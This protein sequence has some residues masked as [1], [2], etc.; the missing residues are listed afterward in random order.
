MGGGASLS[1]SQGLIDK[2]LSNIFPEHP[3][4]EMWDSAAF[5]RYV[6][7]LGLS[8]GHQLTPSRALLFDDLLIRHLN[9]S[10]LVKIADYTFTGSIMEGCIEVVKQS[11]AS[12]RY[13]APRNQG[14][15]NNS[16]LSRLL[17]FY[18]EDVARFFAPKQTLWVDRSTVLTHLHEALRTYQA[19][20]PSWDG[21]NALAFDHLTLDNARRLLTNFDTCNHALLE[22]NPPVLAPEPDGFIGFVWTR[23]DKEL[24]IKIGPKMLEVQ[25]WSP[26]SSY[27]AEGYWEIPITA[28]SEHLA[29][30]AG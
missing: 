5:R 13:S 8:E 23:N 16:L 15:V 24:S 11:T 22:E 4:T 21:E 28:V 20:E 9:Q 26:A 29:W 19:F 17:T 12:I 7:P 10:G 25:R 6:V 3:K 1:N 27:E 30:I 14:S 2:T 18:Q